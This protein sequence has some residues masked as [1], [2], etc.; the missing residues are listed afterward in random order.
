VSGE[1]RR[2]RLR[3]AG[4]SQAIEQ[5]DA[6][7]PGGDTGS[8]PADPV[9]AHRDRRTPEHADTDPADLPEATTGAD[10]RNADRRAAT[11][12]PDAAPAEVADQPA[13]PQPTERGPGVR[14]SGQ[15][16]ERASDQRN[17]QRARGPKPGPQH[18][19]SPA[20]LAD[21]SGPFALTAG[22]HDPEPLVEGTHH[23]DHRF[24]DPAGERGLRG[25]VGG[26]SSQVNVV[27]AMRARDASRPGDEH[28]AAAAADLPIVRRGWVPRE[29]LPKPGGH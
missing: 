8:E 22:V 27:A 13:E 24:D 23:H 6:G 15:A 11:T 10:A 17:R 7:Q 28:L 4:R 3:R 14:R 25:L 26:G 12:G 18:R 2:R 29:D 19:P 5:A 16:G 9:V 20:D 21:L 1:R